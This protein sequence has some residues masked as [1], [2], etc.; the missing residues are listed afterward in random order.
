[1]NGHSMI[2][3]AGAIVG[4]VTMIGLLGLLVWGIFTPRGD[5]DET[6]ESLRNL[7]KRRFAAGEITRE[8]YDKLWTSLELEPREPIGQGGGP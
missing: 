7:L 6:D 1:M 2:G 4:L 5:P 8:E 3:G